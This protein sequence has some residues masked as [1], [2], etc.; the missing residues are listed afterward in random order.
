MRIKMFQLLTRNITKRFLSWKT[1]AL[2]LVCIGTMLTCYQ[3]ISGKLVSKPAYLILEGP[4]DVFVQ[5]VSPDNS[6][7][8]SS[9]LLTVMIFCFVESPV[10]NQDDR[11]YIIRTGKRRWIATE[12][13]GIACASLIWIFLINIM[14]CATSFNNMDWTDWKIYPQNMTCMLIYFLAYTCIG[15]FILLF[16][17]LDIKA[18]GTAVLVTLLVLEKFILDVLPNNINAVSP[19]SD[20]D[21]IISVIRNF[22]FM[23]RMENGF[24]KENFAFSAIYF[25]TI[26]LI[27]AGINISYAKKH[28]VG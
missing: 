1:G 13:L 5:V 12:M 25:L 22:T 11:F 6:M 15:L 19:G 16:H 4:F 14:G 2:V 28:E 27:L 18:L 20:T 26:I 23:N 21:K 17:L 8:I 10:I 3:H 24:Q 7:L 9:V